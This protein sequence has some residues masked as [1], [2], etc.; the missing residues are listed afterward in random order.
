MWAE[1]GVPHPHTSM[2]GRVPCPDRGGLGADGGTRTQ[3]ATSSSHQA[4]NAASADHISSSSPWLGSCPVSPPRLVCLHLGS[5]YSQNVSLRVGV[6]GGASM[7][8]DMGDAG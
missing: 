3:Q 7:A 1:R 5:W 6:C 4:P 8:P 2:A